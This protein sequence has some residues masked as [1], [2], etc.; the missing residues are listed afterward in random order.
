MSKPLAVNLPDFRNLGV[1]LRCLLLVEGGAF[2]FVLASEPGWLE[3][4]LAFM[5]AGIMRE[6][7]LLGSIALLSALSPY[8]A[9][10]SYRS[11]VTWA[12]TLV[13]VVGALGH[14]FFLYWLPVGL[15]GSPFRTGLLSLCSAGF[16]L[17]YFNWRHHALSPA[18]SEARLMA[19]QARIRPHFLFNSLNTVLGLIRTEPRRAESVLENLAELYRALLSEVG[20]LVPLAREVELARAYAEIEVMRLGERLHVNWQCQDAA[21]DALVPPLILQPL[22]ENAVYHGVEPAESGGE[23]SVAIFLNGDQLNLVMRNPCATLSQRQ[24][25]NRMALDNIRERLDLHFD[26]EAEMST[27]KAGDEFVVQIRMPYKHG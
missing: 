12:L 10:V 18:L 2:L 8:L 14:F 24:G 27:Y 19:L 26:A 6:P 21:L 11:G 4:I 9:R 16:V 5:E 7:I 20:A 1:L 22:L 17:A 3:A 15:A 13:F 25:G 23:V